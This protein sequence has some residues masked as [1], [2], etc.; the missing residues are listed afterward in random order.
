MLDLNVVTKPTEAG[1]TQKIQFA[2]KGNEVIVKNFTPGDIFVQIQE[3]GNEIRVPALFWQRIMVGS[4]AEA[5]KQNIGVIYVR[6]EKTDSR[7]V[8]AQLLV[9]E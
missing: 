8:E 1:K 7:G 2:G 9:K 4:N 5:N 3:N 6:A